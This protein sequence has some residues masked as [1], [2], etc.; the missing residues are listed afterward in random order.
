MHHHVRRT[1]VLFIPLLL[2][3]LVKQ[4]EVSQSSES[5]KRS[6]LNSKSSKRRRQK[7]RV[8][9]TNVNERISDLQFRRMFRM[10][11]ECFHLLCQRIISVGEKEFK[12]EAY[13]DAFLKGKDPMYDAH[14]CTSGGYVSGEVKLGIALRL[15]AGGNAIDLGV[16]LT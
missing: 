14:V 15:L 12:S 2:Y 1:I 8:L 4:Y 13:I 9:W 7:K 3:L 11:R 10:D 5:D 16:I 6:I